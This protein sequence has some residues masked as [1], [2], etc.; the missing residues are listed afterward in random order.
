[1]DGVVSRLK[2]AAAAGVSYVDDDLT[3]NARQ[4]AP[5]LI[6]T[7]L[8]DPANCGR[9]EHGWSVKAGIA[10]AYTRV[11]LRD[12]PTLGNRSQL[13]QLSFAS[14]QTGVEP[15]AH[16]LIEMTLCRGTTADDIPVRVRVEDGRFYILRLNNDTVLAGSRDVP[17]L[18]MSRDTVYT[19]KVLLYQ[20]A[21]YAKLSG[22]DVPG[23][24]VE[25]TV[26]DGRRFIPGRPGFGL[27]PNPRASGGELRVF[28]WTVT[29]VGPGGVSHRSDRRFDHR[30]N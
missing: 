8:L 28:D 26:P 29:P 6:R 7:Q 25:L 10:D 3:T 20:K 4:A 12:L 16:G 14:S 15:G 18:T 1:M 5:L 19:L 23:G 27:Q 13:A 9:R 21:V 11:T 24:S 30:R 17:A 22:A 2:T